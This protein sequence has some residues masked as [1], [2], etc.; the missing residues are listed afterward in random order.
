MNHRHGSV[1]IKNKRLGRQKQREA[2]A[3]RNMTVL[4]SFNCECDN[5]ESRAK[6]RSVRIIYTEL[7]CRMS[8]RGCLN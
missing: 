6:R 1:W 5:L 3:A 8:E 7:A 4:A 2:A